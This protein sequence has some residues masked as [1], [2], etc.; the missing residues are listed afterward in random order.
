MNKKCN[1]CGKP[2]MAFK[3]HWLHI[4]EPCSGIADGIRIDMEIVDEGL[5]QK[6]IELYG[7]PEKDDYEVRIELE[8][9]LEELKIKHLRLEAVIEG[10]KLLRWFIRNQMKKLVSKG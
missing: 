9:E 4:E 6:F 7:I 10:N 8:Q 5:N 3:G 1:S 2:L